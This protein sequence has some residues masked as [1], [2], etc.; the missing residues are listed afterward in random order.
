MSELELP[1]EPL[2]LIPPA[3]L[4][5]RGRQLHTAQTPRASSSG[6]ETAL[7]CISIRCGWRTSASS[8]CRVC[9]RWTSKTATYQKKNTNP[10]AGPATRKNDR[11]R[12]CSRRRPDGPGG[13]DLS[14][15]SETS[16]HA[17][18]GKAHATK[19]KKRR[20]QRRPSPAARRAS[21]THVERDRRP[22]PETYPRS[23]F[24]SQFRRLYNRV[25]HPFLSARRGGAAG[26]AARGQNQGRHT[27]HSHSHWRR[28]RTSIRFVAVAV[29]AR[30]RYQILP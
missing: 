25:G 28:R 2:T 7:R 15:G 12:H 27:R 14:R 19:K 13:S 24:L 16:R 10:H 6:D 21:S 20:P 11:T 3:R 5:H 23:R 17:R 1:P 30:F 4:R 9:F 22:T 18:C 26:G 8:G 29:S